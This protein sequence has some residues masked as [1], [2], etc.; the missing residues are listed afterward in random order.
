VPFFPKRS[1]EGDM[2]NPGYV[3][4]LI[5][6][7]MEGLVKIGRTDR[8]PHERAKELSA[9]TG[10]PTPFLVAYD[11]F[12]EDCIG[13][14]QFIHATLELKGY[15]LT[16]NKEFFNCP[17]NEAIKTVIE[18]QSYITSL[19]S[20]QNQKQ[21]EN[22]VAPNNTNLTEPWKESLEVALTYYYGGDQVLQ[23][24]EKSIKYFKQSTKLG[25]AVACGYLGN[26]Y[27]LGIGVVQDL[28]E[29]LDFYDDGAKKG[30]ETCIAYMAMIYYDLQHWENTTK[31]WEKYFSSIEFKQNLSVK[32]A[33]VG[34]DAFGCK[35]YLHSDYPAAVVI[36]SIEVRNR[37]RNKHFYKIR[38]EIISFGNNLLDYLKTN[39]PYGSSKDT[40]AARLSLIESELEHW[41]KIT[42]T[43][44]NDKGFM[45]KIRLSL[46]I[47]KMSTILNDAEEANKLRN[48]F[49]ASVVVP[50][51]EYKIKSVQ[52]DIES[53]GA[54]VEIEKFDAYA[55]PT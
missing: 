23:D 49:P 28:N 27:R 53:S 22:K 6:P 26:M 16:S 47:A 37:I 29:A 40:V 24:Y 33:E 18:A 50:M 31:C 12:F 32:R 55:I 46:L 4:V 8:E 5:N 2:K 1:W 14:E 52:S 38:D 13:A 43:E 48:G 17:P 25:S 45:G 39:D 9:A 41:W 35:D 30:D 51:S 36:K 44:F 15:R 11:S 10:V 3:Y 21:N 34:W 20:N 42:I 7:V 54:K 19:Q